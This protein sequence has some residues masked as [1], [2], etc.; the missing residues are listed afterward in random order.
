MAKWREW[1]EYSM[2]ACMVGKQPWKSALKIHALQAVVERNF[3]NMAQGKKAATRNGGKN[4]RKS[5][6]NIIVIAALKP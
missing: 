1:N 4:W 6:S 2:R 3:S 5:V